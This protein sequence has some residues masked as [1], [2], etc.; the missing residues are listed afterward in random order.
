MEVKH[1]KEEAK[2]VEEAK[3][4]AKQQASAA[5]E[6]LRSNTEKKEM[7]CNTNF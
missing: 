5:I 2:L 6:E 1:Q 4:I 7:K 3:T